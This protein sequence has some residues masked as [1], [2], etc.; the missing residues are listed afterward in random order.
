[1]FGGDSDSVADFKSVRVSV[2]WVDPLSD[3]NCVLCE[4]SSWAL[5]PGIKIAGCT[6]LVC[7]YGASC[8]DDSAWTGVGTKKV[9]VPAWSLGRMLGV[10]IDSVDSWVCPVLLFE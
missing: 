2:N 9:C 7:W 3:A 8:H 1:M 10:S 5:G 6:S 4:V